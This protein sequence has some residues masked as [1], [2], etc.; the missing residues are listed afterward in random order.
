MGVYSLAE[1]RPLLPKEGVAPSARA[2]IMSRVQPASYTHTRYG[3][4]GQ[5]SMAYKDRGAGAGRVARA[6]RTQT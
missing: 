5:Y 6:G 3:A 2:S 1:P 4:I